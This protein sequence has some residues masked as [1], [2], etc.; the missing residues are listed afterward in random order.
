MPGGHA[1]YVT[2]PVAFAAA[3]DPLLP[4][5]GSGSPE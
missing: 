4:D 1:G 3:L 5:D 2:S